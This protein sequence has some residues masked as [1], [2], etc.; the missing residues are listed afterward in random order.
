VK[1]F[2]VADKTERNVSRVGKAKGGRLAGPQTG[3]V[4]T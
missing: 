2:K 4:E 1:G 3:V